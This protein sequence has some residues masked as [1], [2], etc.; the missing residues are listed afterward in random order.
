MTAEKERPSP[1]LSLIELVQIRKSEVENKAPQLIQQEAALKRSRAELL[2][3]E[4][5]ITQLTKARTDATPK[6][7]DAEALRK[8]VEE[9][10]KSDLSDS[11]WKKL[12]EDLSEV[13][14]KIRKAQEAVERAQTTFDQSAIKLARKEMARD[15]AQ[16]KYTAAG[17]ALK[18][19]PSTI[20]R[21][22]EAVSARKAQVEAAFTAQQPRKAYVLQKLLAKALEDLDAQVKMDTE[23]GLIDAFCAAQS[24]LEA[25]EQDLSEANKQHE[26]NR[27]ALKDAQADLQRLQKNRE[28]DIQALYTP[29][30]PAKP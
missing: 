3:Y 25:A 15:A 5:L 8:R 22:A 1:P 6:A 30:V 26:A 13:D 4:P 9:A 17:V 11:V 19:L 24:D 18:G 27:T 7:V 12:D 28:A 21:L 14:K 2:A 16:Q 23:K 10:T 20:T 29:Q